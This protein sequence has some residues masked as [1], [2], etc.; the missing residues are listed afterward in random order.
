MVY[1]SLGAWASWGN[2]PVQNRGEAIWKQTIAIPSFR[3]I[4][5]N[6][7][8]KRRTQVLAS[9]SSLQYRGS[10]RVGSD[11]CQ[12]TFIVFVHCMSSM[13]QT[14][15]CFWPFFSVLLP[16]HL[17]AVTIFFDVLYLMFPVIWWWKWLEN[18][19]KQ[20]LAALCLHSKRNEEQLVH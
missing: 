15:T 16:F 14:F 19:L 17:P 20:I 4:G 18:A 1:K 12:E 9:T 11:R 13:A 2:L 8:S 7:L 5:S 10:T 6:S 3:R